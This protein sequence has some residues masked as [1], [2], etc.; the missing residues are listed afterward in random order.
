MTKTGLEVLEL[1]AESQSL[2]REERFSR[3]GLSVRDVTHRHDRPTKAQ[4][5]LYQ[6]IRRRRV[7]AHALELLSQKLRR[8]SRTPEQKMKESES[9]KKRRP[10]RSQPDLHRQQVEIFWEGS[11]FYYAKPRD[12]KRLGGPFDTMHQAFKHADKSKLE[13][14]EVSKTR[15]NRGPQ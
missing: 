13:V 4:N 7:E 15:G 11:F 14:I 10:G 3:A 1:F 12:S 2:Y 9:Q 5:A 8:A 6:R